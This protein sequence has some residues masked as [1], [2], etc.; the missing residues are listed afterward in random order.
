MQNI[1]RMDIF[2]YLDIYIF[3]GQFL[4]DSYVAEN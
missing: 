3:G 4:K 2:G 1:F